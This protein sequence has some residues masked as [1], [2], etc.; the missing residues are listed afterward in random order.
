MSASV[1]KAVMGTDGWMGWRM[2]LCWEDF[3]SMRVSWGWEGVG[4]EDQ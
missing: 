1:L 2:G 4:L 3:G